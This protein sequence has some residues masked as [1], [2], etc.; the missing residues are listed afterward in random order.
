MLNDAYCSK[1]SNNADNI[2]YRPLH[3]ADFKIITSPSSDPAMWGQKTTVSGVQSSWPGLLALTDGT[4]LGCSAH[5]GVNCHF[6]SF[7]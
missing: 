5:G 7:T 3:G 4:V 6:I 1:P 2:F